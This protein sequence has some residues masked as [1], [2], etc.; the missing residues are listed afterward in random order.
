MF[1]FVLILTFHLGIDVLY[2]DQP[3][4]GVVANIEMSTGFEKHFSRM[5]PRENPKVS[6]STSS[7]DRIIRDVGHH[8]PSNRHREGLGDKKKPAKT[9][10][11]SR[12]RT[13]DLANFSR[14]L[15][16]LSYRP[17]WDKIQAL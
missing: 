2:R 15:S 17:I 7:L 6:M 12:D 11:T 9:N 10:G 8:H 13:S 16:Q 1:I 4:A 3:E 5:K 14:T